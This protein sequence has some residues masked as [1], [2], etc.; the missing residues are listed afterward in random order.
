MD[1]TDDN[2]TGNPSTFL[3]LNR[4]GVGEDGGIS[5]LEQ[6]VLDEYARLARNMKTVCVFLLYNA[7]VCSGFSL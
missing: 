5:P 2:T 1:D 7:C 3:N 6:D 4:S